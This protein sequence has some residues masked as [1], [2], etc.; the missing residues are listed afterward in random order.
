MCVSALHET[1]SKALQEHQDGKRKEGDKT[2]QTL[3]CLVQVNTSE[4]RS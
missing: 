3:A 4:M 1:D 2:A